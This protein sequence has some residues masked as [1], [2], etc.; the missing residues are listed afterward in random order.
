MGGVA[1][2]AGMPVH[3]H[4]ELLGRNRERKVEEAFTKRFGMTV[5]NRRHKIESARQGQHGRKSSDNRGDLPIEASGKKR[6]VGGRPIGAALET[7]TCCPSLYR[8][9]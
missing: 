1:I 4:R 3:R 8:C 6:T 7:L 2:H 5:R 9:G